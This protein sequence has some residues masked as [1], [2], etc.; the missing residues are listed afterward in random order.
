M[1]ISVIPDAA[2][3]HIQLAGEVVEPECRALPEEASALLAQAARPV[4][5]DFTGVTYINSAGL[6]A[7]V[8]TYKRAREHDQEMAL[9][10]LRE[11]VLKIFKLARL[12]AVFPEFPSPEEA[13][14]HLLAE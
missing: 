11:D 13:K 5:L 1:E 2:V 9:C 3:H 14:A 4:L 10:C 7:C 6:G 8:A 12:T